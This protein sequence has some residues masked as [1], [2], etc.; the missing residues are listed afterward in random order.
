MSN[1]VCESKSNRK[2]LTQ[3]FIINICMY[4]TYIECPK[5]E[6]PM[7]SQS[8]EKCACRFEVWSSKAINQGLFCTRNWSLNISK[9][10]LMM[11]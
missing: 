6:A 9:I 3:N 1:S 5:F 7:I 11:S 10:A 2:T 8:N 4:I